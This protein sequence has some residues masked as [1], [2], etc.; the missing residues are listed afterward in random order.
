MPAVVAVDRTVRK[1]VPEKS[2][3]TGPGDGDPADPGVA[4]GE[5]GG[6]EPPSGGATDQ[7]AP[8]TVGPV[9]ENPPSR[10]QRRRARAPWVRRH[11]PTLAML[12]PNARGVHPLPRRRGDGPRIGA[13]GQSGLGHP[14]LHRAV[15][16]ST[17]V[18]A[19]P[20]GA[21]LMGRQLVPTHRG[22][23]LLPVAGPI[24]DRPGIG[25]RVSS[26]CGRSC[27]GECPTIT[28]L[29]P[30]VVGV[31]LGLRVR[32]RGLGGPVVPGTSPL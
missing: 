10:I 5:G 8:G 14:P 31:A 19:L 6:R 18:L 26:R 3:G 2:T 7:A 23:W 21:G 11:R 12:Q 4:G 17:Q 13:R 9:D 16:Q 27:S 25:L 24:P 22:P 30:I 28:G 1:S 29:T 32:G 15:A 20:A